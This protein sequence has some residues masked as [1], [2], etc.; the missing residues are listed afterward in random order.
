[1]WFVFFFYDVRFVFSCESKTHIT[2]IYVLLGGGGRFIYYDMIVY[3]IIILLRPTTRLLVLTTC[4]QYNIFL[5]LF[6][7]RTV[8]FLYIT[9]SDTSLCRYTHS[10]P[11]NTVFG[12]VDEGE[13]IIK[14]IFGGNLLSHFIIILNDVN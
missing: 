12:E 7:P 8:V 13:N 3:E 14:Y 1:M 5:T 4:L 2:Y 9:F 6:W 11:A 10:D